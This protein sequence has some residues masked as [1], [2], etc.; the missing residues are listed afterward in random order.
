MSQGLTPKQ[1]RFVA[2]Y[3]VDLNA[4]QAA[5]RAGYSLKTAYSI[6]NENLKKPEIAAAIAERQSKIEAA[7]GVTVEKVINALWTEATRT[8][9]EASHAAR[10]A[11]LAHLGKHLGMFVERHE[12]TGR[13][14]GPIETRSLSDAELAER[15]AKLR[16]RLLASAAPPYTNGNGKH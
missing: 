6:G 14:G 7:T 15:A 11:A 4:T 3:L 12:H 8:G 5:I 13:D 1:A 9:E 16:N 10:V 2:E